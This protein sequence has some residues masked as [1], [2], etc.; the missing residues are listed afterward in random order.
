[1]ASTIAHLFHSFPGL[2]KLANEAAFDED[3]LKELKKELKELDDRFERVNLLQRQLGDLQEDDMVD[4]VGVQ[5]DSSYVRLKSQLAKKL[6]KLQADV[7]SRHQSLA[8][9]IA[10]RHTE[11]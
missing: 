5:D 4:A 11:L 10:S 3:Q 7:K 2:W 9:R 6:K 1:M 8:Q